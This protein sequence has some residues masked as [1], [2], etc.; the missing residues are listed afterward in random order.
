MRPS[1]EPIRVFLIDDHPIVREAFARSAQDEADISVLGGAGTAAEGLSG[2]T[3]AHPDV[4]LV[5][6]SLPDGD[7]P[8][9]IAN[10]RAALPEARV[11][12]LSGYEDEL[13]VAEAF[14]AGAQ[15]YIIKTSKVDDVLAAVRMAARGETPVSPK[16][17]EPLLRAMRR[18]GS[19][20]VDSLTARERE[21]FLRFAAGLTTR[22]VAA[23]LGIS[24]KTVETHRVRIYEKLGCK[25]V[26]ELAR[27]AVR[28]G[29]VDA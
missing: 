28:A 24:P 23:S 26:V 12:V 15:G 13:R 8:T 22:E 10:L 7:G 2:A 21:V 18:A 19:G 25:T 16:L 5:D 29:L 9:L 27:L 11:V 20:T 4:V 6:L 3:A 14:R 17:T 1:N